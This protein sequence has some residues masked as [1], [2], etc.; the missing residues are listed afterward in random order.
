MAKTPTPHIG[1]QYGEIAE[2]VIMAGDPLRVKLTRNISTMQCV[3]I[4][5]VACWAS[6]APIRASASA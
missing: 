6:P 5:C 2:T 1:A 3:L 4:K